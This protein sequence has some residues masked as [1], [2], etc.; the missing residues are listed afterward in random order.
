MGPDVR[1]R[2]PNDKRCLAREHQDTNATNNGAPIHE[3]SECGTKC[4]VVVR[5]SDGASVVS[6]NR[7]RLQSRFSFFC[8][9]GVVCVCWLERKRRKRGEKK[10]E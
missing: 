3:P 1:R 10:E 2:S 7:R 5:A 9:C 6:T 8:E 4:F